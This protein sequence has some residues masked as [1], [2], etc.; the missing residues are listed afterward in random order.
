MG[1]ENVIWAKN[2]SNSFA[3]LTAHPSISYTHVITTT[4]HRRTAACG[5][6]TGEIFDVDVRSQTNELFDLL[7]VAPDGGHVEGSLSSLVPLVNFV[8]LSGGGAAGNFL[9]HGGGL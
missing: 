6:H 3:P 9:L 7:H 1:K 8:F 4:W 5:R 2:I